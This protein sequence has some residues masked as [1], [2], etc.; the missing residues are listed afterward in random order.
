MKNK[1]IVVAPHADDEI[2]GCGGTIAKAISQG[3][4]VYII[5]A[6]NANVGAPELFNEEAITKVRGEALKAHE[7]LGV[8]KTFFLDFP[9]P[10][11]NAFPEYKVSVALSKIFNEVQPNILYLPHPGDLHQD[12]KAVYRA[13][14]VAAR[15]QGA[16]TIEQIYCYETLSET[17]WAPYQ[18]K[19]FIP[20]MF[21]DISDFFE[22]KLEAMRFFKSQIKEFPHTRSTET[23]EA[24][25]KFR[26]AT[27]G[28]KRAES[29][30]VERIITK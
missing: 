24:L 17:E 23:F 2:I 3:D 27:V 28:V 18:E 25:A 8:T 15:P 6:T 13:S 30:I 9:A 5:I 16:Y 1:I 21:N 10:A 14:L 4:E 19:A 7:Y 12:H 29:F 11:L 20:N 26:G 22:Q